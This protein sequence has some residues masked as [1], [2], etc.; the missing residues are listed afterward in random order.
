[1]PK[2]LKKMQIQIKLDAVLEHFGVNA[3][4][5]SLFKGYTPKCLTSE[6]KIV[7]CNLIV[8]IVVSIVNM[9]ALI[10]YYISGKITSHKLGQLVK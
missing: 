3:K 10:E 1:M 2:R 5:W 7:D 6:V 8:T 9:L 4:A